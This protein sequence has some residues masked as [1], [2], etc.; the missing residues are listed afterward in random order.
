MKSMRPPLTYL[1]RAGGDGPL[2]HPPLGSATEFR[3]C[4]SEFLDGRL[5][6]F[7]LVVVVMVVQATVLSAVVKEDFTMRVLTAG[8]SMSLITFVSTVLL[9]VGLVNI[10]S[11]TLTVG[12]LIVANCSCRVSATRLTCL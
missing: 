5:I 3:V 8:S 9:L 11:C 10:P 4:W 12:K 1:H 7:S 6:D 2:G